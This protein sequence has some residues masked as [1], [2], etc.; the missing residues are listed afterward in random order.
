MQQA[1]FEEITP[2]KAFELLK[3][4]P[5]NRG[6]KKGKVRSYAKEMTEGKWSG[7]NG[8]TI[9]LTS[10][11][12]LTDGQHRLEAVILS[13]VPQRF[14]VVRGVTLE[15]M[16][17]VDIGTK[18]TGGDI[19][20]MNGVLAHNRNVLAAA[21]NICAAFKGNVYPAV[22]SKNALTPRDVYQYYLDHPEI[23]ES[24]LS[25]GGVHH[26]I[27]ILC[28][29]SILVAL[30]YKF[31]QIDKKKADDFV[32][33]FVYGAD[34]SAGDPILEVR[35][36]IIAERDKWGGS[37]SAGLR[38]RY[39]YLLVKAFNAFMRGQKVKTIRYQAEAPAIIGEVFDEGIYEKTV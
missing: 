16:K 37:W 35:N 31:S 38:H 9:K 19:F 17:T 25:L 4:N 20:A 14:L 10:E 26:K 8:E 2:E 23:L 28:P 5:K 15:S 11:G 24:E 6:L 30:H 27:K 18:R 33:N 7:E 12:I 3:N 13:G 34:L 36:R 22:Q 39:I 21:I 1:T 29:V 32:F